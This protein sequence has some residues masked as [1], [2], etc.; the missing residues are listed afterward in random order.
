MQ[1]VAHLRLVRNAAAD[2]GEKLWVIYRFRVI[3][4]IAFFRQRQEA[5]GIC[6]LVE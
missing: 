2:I 6:P 5:K 1:G 4:L 3:C